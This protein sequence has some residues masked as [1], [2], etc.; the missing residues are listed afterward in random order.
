MRKETEC[1]TNIHEMGIYDFCSLLDTFR[2]A[3]YSKIA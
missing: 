3:E 2:M 1:W